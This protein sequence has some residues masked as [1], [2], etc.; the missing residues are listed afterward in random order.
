M[1]IS[2]KLSVMAVVG[3][4]YYWLNNNAHWLV[5]PAHDQHWLMVD[6]W[7]VGN[8]TKLA[9]FEF[10]PHTAG[11]CPIVWYQ[12]M[13]W[14]PLVGLVVVGSGFIKALRNY[15]RRAA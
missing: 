3:F 8:T 6:L 11:W 14:F 13:K 12:S 4:V 15:V 1:K 5:C 10:A 7:T 2:L 9:V